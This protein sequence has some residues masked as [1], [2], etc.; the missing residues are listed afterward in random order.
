M[1]GNGMGA[2]P[3]AAAEKETQIKRGTYGLAE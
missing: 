2:T 1:P 3:A